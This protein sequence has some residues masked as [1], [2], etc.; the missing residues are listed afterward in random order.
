MNLLGMLIS[1]GAVA[2]GLK[3]LQEA[4]GGSSASLGRTM[5]S[6]TITAPGGLTMKVHTVH[7]IDQRV[8]HCVDMIKK[9]RNDPRI[10]A[11]AVQIVSQK[12]ANGQWACKERDYVCE[13]TALFD[14]MRQNVRYV[15]DSIDRDTFQHPK[16]T[17][18]FAGG[19]C[20][21]YTITLGALL[22][23]IGYP[24][25]CRVIRTVGSKDFDHIYLVAGL[26]PTNPTHR[27]ALDASVDKPAGWSA[28]AGMVVETRDFHVPM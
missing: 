5:P 16:R 12:R 25:W 26:P 15:R 22:Q 3:G 2:G 14:Y 27:I 21:D 20:D 18:E 13:C 23:S 4:M 24:V 17:L 6:K 9:G 19:D 8:K 11:L 1:A 28:P 10:R 7:N